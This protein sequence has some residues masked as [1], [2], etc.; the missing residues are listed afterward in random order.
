MA[1]G[2]TVSKISNLEE[3]G[4]E[5]VSLTVDNPKSV[6][7]CHEKVKQLLKGKGLDFLINNAGKSMASVISPL[8]RTSLLIV[9][10]QPSI[11]QQRRPTW[12]R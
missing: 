10:S 7:E 2:R 4:I 11:D 6:A 8:W 3:F 5:C 12:A 1:T 9:L